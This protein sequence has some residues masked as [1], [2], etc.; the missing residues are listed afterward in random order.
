M[1]DWRSTRT[2]RTTRKVDYS[3]DG[4]DDIDDGVG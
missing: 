3:Y 1:A 2:R 4:G